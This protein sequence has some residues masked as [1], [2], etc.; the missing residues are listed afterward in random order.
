MVDNIT[1]EREIR[2][3]NENE[4]ERFMTM[5]GG[6]ALILCGLSRRSFAGLLLA[7]AG[8]YLA[9]RNYSR[10]FPDAPPASPAYKGSPH[11]RGVERTRQVDMVDET[12]RQSFPASDPPAWTPRR[13]ASG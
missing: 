1:T 5:L 2:R 11:P 4:A 13:A 8:A 6:G 10:L 9:Y 7:L 12:S 3:Q